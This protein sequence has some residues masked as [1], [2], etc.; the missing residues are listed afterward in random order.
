MCAH[1]SCDLDPHFLHWPALR[2]ILLNSLS[3]ALRWRFQATVVA[4][5]CICARRMGL[6][7]LLM[8]ERFTPHAKQSWQNHIWIR[9]AIPFQQ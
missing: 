8:G 7:G 3:A 4:A 2:T 9:A 6:V 1:S 5:D